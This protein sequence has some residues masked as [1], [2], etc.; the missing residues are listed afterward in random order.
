MTPGT[1][2]REATKGCGVTMTTEAMPTVDAQ[3]QASVQQ[4]YATHMQLLDDGRIEE[5]ASYF[6]P[7]GTF[8]VGGIPM[9]ARGR[10][11]IVA[12]ASRT[13]E[14]LTAQGI[15]RRH[16]L[17]MSAIRPLDGEVRVRSYALV[18]QVTAEGAALR[19]STTCEDVLV[20][21]SASWLIKERIVRQDAPV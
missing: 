8:A 2:G 14:Q 11:E 13:V 20:P 19:S 9:P 12:G 21:N 7:E 6:T 1:P 15:T 18:F 17:S 4:F 3:L 16:W 10:E 5:W